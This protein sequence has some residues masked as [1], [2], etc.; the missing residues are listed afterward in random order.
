[1]NHLAHHLII[2]KLLPE[3]KKTKGRCI[4]VGSITGNTNTVG[5]GAVLP[6]ARSLSPLPF[7][8]VS[9]LPYSPHLLIFPNLHNALLC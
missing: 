5:G 3:L 6:L 7:F 4:I 8:L 2:K 9:F 1:M